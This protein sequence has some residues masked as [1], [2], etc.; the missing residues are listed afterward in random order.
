M[1]T[2]KQ[3]QKLKYICLAAEDRLPNKP[4]EHDQCNEPYSMNTLKCVGVFVCMGLC[5]LKTVG[6]YCTSA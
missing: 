5:S 3:L 2:Y 1:Y 6:M 4:N